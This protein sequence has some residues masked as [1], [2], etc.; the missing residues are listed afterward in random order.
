MSVTRP[1]TYPLTGGVTADVSGKFAY[2]GGGG[3]S[4]EA[5][6]VLDRLTAPEALVQT[7]IATFVDA[8]VAKGNWDNIDEFV[9]TCLDTSANSLI[10][11]R[12]LQNGSLAGTPTF[13][14]YEGFDCTTS[15][16]ID[17]SLIPS[18][19]TQYQQNDAFF[20]SYQH[21]NTDADMAAFGTLDVGPNRYMF[22]RKNSTSWRVACNQGSTSVTNVG[23]SMPDNTALTMV[24][25]DASNMSQW[26]GAVET[27]YVVA[28][29]ARSAESVYVNGFNNNGAPSTGGDPVLCFYACGAV[30]TDITGWQSDVEQL[31]TDLGVPGA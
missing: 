29:S 17:T 25:V 21:G 19:L 5:Q 26:I 2:D 7:S 30:P 28:S 13:T 9:V 14:A 31:M 3:F 16:Y 6:E 4:A 23:G 22:L 11:L 1:V 8:C 10:G 15:D 12:G 24:R 20:T 27:A 18:S